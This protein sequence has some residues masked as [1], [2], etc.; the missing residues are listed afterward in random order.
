V[1][2][3]PVWD[4]FQVP[5][6]EASVNPIQNRFVEVKVDLIKLSSAEVSIVTSHPPSLEQEVSASDQDTEEIIL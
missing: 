2:V 6:L 3:F 5:S 1:A 4:H